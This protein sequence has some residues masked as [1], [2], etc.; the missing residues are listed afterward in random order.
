VTTIA[1]LEQETARRLGPFQIQ[2]VDGTTPA[3]STVGYAVVP[4][5]QSLIGLNTID[6]LF[7][8]RRG[9]LA[10]GTASPVVAPADRQRMVVD[11]DPSS[12]RVQVDRTWQTPPAPNE[13]LEFMHLDPAQELRPAVMAGL[14]RC[15]VS[16]RVLLGPGYIYE[17]D[18][19]ASLPW[20]QH[21][22]Q[23]QRVQTGPYPSGY[24]GWAGGPLDVPYET[25]MECGHVW[26][27]VGGSAA[28][29]PFYGGLLLTLIR[30]ADSLT[31]GGCSDVPSS[32]SDTIAIDIEY[33]AAACH[34]EA[35]KRIPARMQAASAAGW[36][37]TKA[38]AAA[39]FTRQA[40]MN[41][42]QAHDRYAFRRSS[43]WSLSGKGGRTVV[44]A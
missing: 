11:L 12:G 34:I 38:E 5:L 28:W 25:F 3:T 44:N 8:L 22:S 30:P 39:E 7:L 17:C 10:N 13:Q 29:G 21:A 41:E 18:L 23:V 43:L 1:E 19:T 14:H 9:T 33:A 40:Y 42:P 31:G 2:I 24:P 15:L 37:T 26:L 4:A 32:D 27:R 20:L 36:Q 16:E 35:W 6:N